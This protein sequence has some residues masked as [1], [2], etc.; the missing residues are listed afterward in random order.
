MSATENRRFWCFSRLTN[1]RLTISDKYQ[2]WDS[3]PHVL[4]GQ[5]IL[6]PSCLPIAPPGL[7]E[8]LFVDALVHSADLVDHVLSIIDKFVV[9]LVIGDSQY[10]ERQQCRVLGAT[11]CQ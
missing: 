5:R 9:K 7:T 3:N 1:Y 4:I 8:N 2:G 6:R 10:L 11:D